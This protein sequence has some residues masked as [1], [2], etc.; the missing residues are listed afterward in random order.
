MAPETRRFTCPSHL[1]R[2]PIVQRRLMV[3]EAVIPRPVVR[4]PMAIVLPLSRSPRTPTGRFGRATA[5]YVN[6][7]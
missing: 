5:S 2:R 6:C 1:R 7:P 3:G 4:E